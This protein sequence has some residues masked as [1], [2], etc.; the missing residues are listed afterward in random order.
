MS[1][2]LRGTHA[3]FWVQEGQSDASLDFLQSGG[4][5]PTSMSLFSP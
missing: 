1:F 4:L 2:N 5:T 3:V